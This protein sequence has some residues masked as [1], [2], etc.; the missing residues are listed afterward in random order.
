MRNWY[1][2]LCVK[3]GHHIVP[4]V[5]K[6]ESMRNW[7]KMS[8]VKF[9]H[10]IL[11]QVLRKDNLWGIDSAKCCAWNS[12]TTLYHWYLEKPICEQLIQ[13]V[14]REIRTQLSITGTQK[15]QFVRNW[16]KMLCV[17]FRHNFLPLLLRKANLWGIDTTCCVWNS[18]TTLYH[19]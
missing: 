12:D 11:T 7:C 3:F 16:F 6:S 10:N 19:W 1:N 17:K 2:M 5:E 13:H 9:R 15:S 8:S 18:D 4:L 14:V